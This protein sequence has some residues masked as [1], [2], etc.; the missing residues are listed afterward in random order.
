MDPER[1]KIEHLISLH[2]EVESLSTVNR[3]ICRYFAEHL[4]RWA[5]LKPDN[6]VL[7]AN[8]ATV[9]NSL[10]KRVWMKVYGSETMPKKSTLDPKILQIYPDLPNL[11]VKSSF[12][13]D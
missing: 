5:A 12:A 8:V 13:P 7:I 3:L 9:Y 6:L 2:D 10:I 4:P 1:S 11:S